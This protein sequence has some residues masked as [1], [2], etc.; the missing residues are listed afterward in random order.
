MKVQNSR[1]SVLTRVKAFAYDYATKKTEN[2]SSGD[3]TDYTVDEVSQTLYYYV[4]NDGLYKRKLSDSKAER[5]YK[6]VENETNI[7][8]LSFDGKYLYMSMNNILFTFSS[9]QILI[10]MLW[11][12]TEMN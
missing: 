12:Q 1:Q 4:F 3:I 2:I 10:Y 6:M 8:Q 5:I 7:C 11:I 9:V